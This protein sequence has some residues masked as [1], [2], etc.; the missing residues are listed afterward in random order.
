MNRRDFFKKSVKRILPYIG[1][2]ATGTI[3]E[4]KAVAMPLIASDCHEACEHSC[5]NL[6]AQTCY[7]KC[8]HSC[9]NGCTR[10]CR[11][12]CSDACSGC[13]I[14]CKGRCQ[15]SC[16]GSCKITAKVESDSLINKTILNI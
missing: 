7:G 15:S 6:C 8:K 5:H 10:S 4:T 9:R 2:I 14:S 11:G 1:I 13:Q 12:M 3:F 16:E